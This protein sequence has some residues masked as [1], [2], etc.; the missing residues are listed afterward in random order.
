METEIYTFDDEYLNNV[1]KEIQVYGWKM[2]VLSVENVF[3]N[4][5]F[6]YMVCLETV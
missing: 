4:G 1:G 5:N 2:K 6:C 3:H